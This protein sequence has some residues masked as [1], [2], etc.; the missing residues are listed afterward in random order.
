[1]NQGQHLVGHGVLQGGNLPL[2]LQFEVA[3]GDQFGGSLVFAEQVHWALRKCSRMAWACDFVTTE[4]SAATSSCLTACRLPK[5]SSRRRVVDSPTPG[6]SLSSVVRS[7]IWRRLRWKVTAK[8]CASSR[9]SCTRCN[10]GE[11]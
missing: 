1:M 6:I 8:R 10:T 7:L 3:G 9:I 11:W 4:D 5:C 2:A